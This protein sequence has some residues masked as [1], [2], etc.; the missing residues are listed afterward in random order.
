MYTCFRPQGLRRLRTSYIDVVQL[1]WNDY[2]DRGYVDAALLLQDFE[3]QGLIRHVGLTNFDSKRVAEISDSGV[4]V[5]SN[6][7]ALSHQ[8]APER[9]V[10][11]VMVL[12]ASCGSQVQ[13][14]LFDRRVENGMES[15]CR[16]RKISILPYGEKVVTSLSYLSNTPQRQVNKCGFTN[17]GVL[18]GGFLSDKYLGLSPQ[19]V[20]AVC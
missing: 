17:S 16:E 1:Y 20:I 7:V 6:Q 13:Y 19:K 18:A 3:S 14:S 10:P 5:L 9:T 2:S 12:F 15:L 8:N 4:R 11:N